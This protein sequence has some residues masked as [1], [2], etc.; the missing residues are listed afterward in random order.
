M[1]FVTVFRVQS[2]AFPVRLINSLGHLSFK[3]RI[4]LDDPDRIKFDE[5]AGTKIQVGK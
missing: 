5:S 4:I 3:Q 2:F 1:V